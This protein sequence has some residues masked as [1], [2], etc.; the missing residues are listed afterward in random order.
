VALALKILASNASPYRPTGS[1]ST[2]GTKTSANRR[3]WEN[4][5]AEVWRQKSNLVEMRRRAVDDNVYND[6]RRL[7]GG[8]PG[9]ILHC[10][11]SVRPSVCLS[12]PYSFSIGSWLQ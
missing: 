11:P 7:L 12:V 9:N 6:D 2:D 10:C 8:T 5:T 4:R 3:S 1:R